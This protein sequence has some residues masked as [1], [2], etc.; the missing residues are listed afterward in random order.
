MV[1]DGVPADEQVIR[2]NAPSVEPDAPP[3]VQD[4]TPQQ[5]V[6]EVDGNPSLPMVNRQLA[7]HW[8]EGQ[9]YT[10]GWLA[11]A[12]DQSH[13]EIINRQIASSGFNAQQEAAGIQGHGT[14]SYAVGIEPVKDL[15]EGGKF[16]NDYF[17]TNE[18]DI[19]DEVTRSIGPPQVDGDVRSAV[20][21]AG[22]TAA[23]DAAQANQYA[24]FYA[25]LQGK[26]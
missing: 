20:M 25:S 7:S 24:A 21:G 13:A 1:R 10:P 16:G 4:D 11:A 2:H 18:K 23:R 3:A 8:V 9:Q 14:M 22:K 12:S 19:Q 5:G 26:K 15:T 17:K 6:V